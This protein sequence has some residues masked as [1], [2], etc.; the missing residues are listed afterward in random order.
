MEHHERQYEVRIADSQKMIEIFIKP[1]HKEAV[2]HVSSR[3]G[4]LQNYK[5]QKL[6][7]SLKGYYRHIGGG[8]SYIL[9]KEENRKPIYREV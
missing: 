7:L 3:S 5:N 9:V 6:E 1:T 4:N 8:Y 2:E